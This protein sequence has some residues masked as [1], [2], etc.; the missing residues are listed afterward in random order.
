MANPILFLLFDAGGQAVK[1]PLVEIPYSIN[2]KDPEVRAV[3]SRGHTAK[4]F[5][6]LK[7][8][9]SAGNSK[10]F[11]VS[12]TDNIGIYVDIARENVGFGRMAR[13]LRYAKTDDDAK[14]ADDRV[15]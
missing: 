2:D 3:H 8:L 15:G 4:T 10:A 6:C 5:G 14:E 9:D 7:K 1:S 12:V 13:Q 11:F